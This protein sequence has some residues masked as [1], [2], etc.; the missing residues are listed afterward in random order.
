MDSRITL[1]DSARTILTK[2]GV[3][4]FY[5]GASA[6]CLGTMLQ[7]GMVMS[8]YELVHA[9]AESHPTMTETV[10]GSHGLQKRTVLAGLCA[11]V[12]RAVLECPFEY[13]KVRQMTR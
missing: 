13:V 11:G 12:V 2:E 10:Q 3:P 4:G 9:G 8:T 7:R 6:I 5:R 1:R